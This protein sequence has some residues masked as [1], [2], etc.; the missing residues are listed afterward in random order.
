LVLDNQTLT[1]SL[2]SAHSY[3]QMSTSYFHLLV[4][5]INS[6]SDAK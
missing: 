3:S 6:D 1:F 2:D 5:N 4:H